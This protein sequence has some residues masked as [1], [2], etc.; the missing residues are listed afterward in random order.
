[1]FF[2]GYF[3]PPFLSLF[4]PLLR[5]P[6]RLLPP[7]FDSIHSSVKLLLPFF[8]STSFFSPCERSS[9]VPVIC[10]M[11]SGGRHSTLTYDNAPNA[12]SL[13]FFPPPSP[14]PVS[15]FPCAILLKGPRTSPILDGQSWLLLSPGYVFL[16]SDLCTSLQLT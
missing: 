14:T 5:Y 12:A 13:L 2:S 16:S 4:S 7:L 8:P 6:F 9:H 10:W 11:S 1:V 15:S 3:S